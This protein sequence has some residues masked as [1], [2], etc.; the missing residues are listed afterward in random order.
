MKKRTSKGAHQR[1]VGQ[2]DP[3]NPGDFARSLPERL[4]FKGLIS[5]KGRF[6]IRFLRR[7]GRHARDLSAILR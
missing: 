4:D 7:R 2:Y 6:S 1:P 3:L 5:G